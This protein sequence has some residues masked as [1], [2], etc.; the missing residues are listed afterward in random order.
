M[1]LRAVKRVLYRTKT[2]NGIHPSSH[3]TIIDYSTENAVTR[4][5]ALPDELQINRRNFEI[6]L[7]ILVLAVFALYLFELPVLGWEVA[8]FLFEAVILLFPGLLALSVFAGVLVHRLR[9]ISVVDG[10]GD[11]TQPGDIAVTRILALIVHGGLAVTTLWWVTG[12]IYTMYIARIR[13]IPPSIVALFYGGVLATVVM[14]ERA[15]FS[16]FRGGHW[17]D[18]LSREPTSLIAES[19]AEPETDQVPQACYFTLA[20]KMGALPDQWDDIIQSMV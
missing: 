4:M 8:E 13:G 7:S 17:L 9:L 16:I 18:F 12:S 6:I 20:R 5:L 19:K 14:I 15:I 1:E 3:R 11:R 2:A 10:A